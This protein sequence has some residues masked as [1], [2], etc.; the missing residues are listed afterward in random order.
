MLEG[1][2]KAL[3]K[4]VA[5]ALLMMDEDHPAATAIRGAGWTIPADY[6]EVRR[7]LRSLLL[8]P[9]EDYGISLRETIRNYWPWLVALF[10]LL[11]AAIAFG[12][13]ISILRKRTNRFAKRLTESEQKFRVLFERAP[14]SIMVHDR[15]TGLIVDANLQALKAYGVNSL[16]ELQEMELWGDPPYSYDEV[17]E[18]ISKVSE[19]GA[20]QFEWLS[21]TKNG[22]YFWE[23]VL[24]QEV[25]F[26]NEVRHVSISIDIT[27]RKEAEAALRKS[28]AMFRNLTDNLSVG[29]AMI[30]RE[31]EVLTVNPQMQQWFPESGYES[32]PKCYEAFN[33][34]S[35]HGICADCPVAKSLGDGA[36]HYLEREVDTHLGKRVFGI[37]ATAIKDHDGQINA[38]IEMVDDITERKQMEVNL[39]E[40]KKQAEVANKAKSEFLANMSHEI[41]TPLNGVIGFTELLKNTELSETQRLYAQNAHTAG[42]SL[43]DIINDILDFSKIEAGKLNLDI[44]KTDILE[45]ASEAVDIIQFHA[46]KKGLE[47]LL[48]IQPDA[49][50]F[51]HADPVRLK[52]ILINLLSNAVKFTEQGEVELKLT[53]EATDGDK[54]IF[55]YAV[56]DTGIGMTSEQQ[57]RVFDAF[58]QADTS[59]TRKYGGT[60]LGLPISGLLASKMG[61]RI[62]LESEEGKGS[63]F[64]FTLRTKYEDGERLVPQT[65]LQVKHI[66]VVDDN[67][68]NRLILEH[69]LAYWDITFTGCESGSEALELIRDGQVF[70]VILMDYHM[71]GMNGLD[72]TQRIREELSMP[73]EKQ[74]IILL[75]SSSDDAAVLQGGKKA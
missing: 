47:L 39:Q 72:A 71:P 38:A 61:S 56:R 23:D 46:S 48:N 53:F 21:Q 22:N 9:Y 4:Q 12:V 41:R 24:V 31:M 64:Y 20:H 66:L 54:G 75:H 68:N 25:H 1:T 8:P 10:V 28:E 33:Y 43:L 6:V 35:K 16:R 73:A 50:R 36:L 69:L 26:G 13:I 32:C 5:I 27:S 42:E 70:D 3:S 37:T 52:Q 57:A 62:E 7:L 34:P 63:T 14:V 74:P 30:N 29:V 55:R 15:Q 17:L 45:L 60:G 18:N 40:A 59:T 51:I 11:V 65:P 44:V 2:N 19:K 49:P 67:D 58:M